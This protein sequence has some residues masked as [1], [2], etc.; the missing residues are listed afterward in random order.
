MGRPNEP[1]RNW[2]ALFDR[3]L[4]ASHR[5]A[6]EMNLDCLAPKVNVGN[7]LILFF[8]GLIP[9]N[10]IEGADGPFHS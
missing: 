1:L 8:F 9:Q 3:I 7:L 4:S 6:I 10:L 5:A 2:L